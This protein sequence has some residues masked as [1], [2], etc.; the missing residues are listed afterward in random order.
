M[1]KMRNMH[2]SVRLIESCSSPRGLFARIF[3]TAKFNCLSVNYE[4]LIQCIILYK[5]FNMFCIN[6]AYIISN[7]F[8]IF[9]AMDAENC[10]NFYFPERSLVRFPMSS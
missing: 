1:A 8:T 7:L 2:L 10:I 4:A 3:L 5:L 9:Y 6:D